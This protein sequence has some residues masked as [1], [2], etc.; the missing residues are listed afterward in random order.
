M[1]IHQML[2]GNSLHRELDESFLTVDAESSE[3]ETLGGGVKGKLRGTREKRKGKIAA[4]IKPIGH[5]KFK[6]PKFIRDLK[7]LFRHYYYTIYK[8]KSS[9]KGKGKMDGGAKSAKQKQ[10]AHSKRAV[11]SFQ[12]IY[13]MIAPIA[14]ALKLKSAEKRKK[15]RTIAKK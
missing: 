8:E 10:M 13:D 15:K 6:A 4:L 3:D 7:N 12:R 5:A 1:K 14:V 9:G 2:G 11:R